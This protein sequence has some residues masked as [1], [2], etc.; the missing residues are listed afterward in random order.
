MGKTKRTY[1]EINEKIARKEAVVMT[2]EEVIALKDEQGIEEATRMVDVVTTG[3]FGPMC[4]SGAFFNL[5]HSDPPIKM[6]KVWLNDVMAYGG[7]AAVDIYLG[8]TQSAESEKNNYGGAH[9]IEEFIKGHKI[10]M[11][12]LSTGTDCYPAREVEALISKDTVNQA[13]MV[14]PRNA[15]QNYNVAVN[16]SNKKIYTYMGTLL[17]DLGN[18][19][20]STSGQ[21]SPLLKDPDLRTIGVGTRIFIGGTEGYVIWEGTQCYPQSIPV[22]GQE[23]VSRQGATLAVIGDLKKMSPDFL[24]AAYFTGYGVSLYVGIGI[25]IPVLDEDILRAASVKDEEI[26]TEVFDYSCPHPDKPSLGWVNYAQ[27]RSGQIELKGNKVLTSSLSSYA[28]AREIAQSLKEKVQEGLFFIQ[29]PVQ[30]F[31]AQQKLK[32]LKSIRIY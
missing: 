15:C 7:L 9:V 20:Y 19:A 2:A 14:N 22:P 26:F 5:G 32:R 29:E 12:A 23:T 21:L 8:A 13:F 4:S 18:A 30:F 10:K 28:K 25:P 27:L 6:Q 24:Q 11:K 3:T 17:P 16:Q 31:S 1:Q